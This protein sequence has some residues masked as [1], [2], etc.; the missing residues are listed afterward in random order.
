MTVN[1]WLPPALAAAG[2]LLGGAAYENTAMLCT[3]RYQVH[4]QGLPRIVQVSDLHRRVFGENQ[5]KLIEAVRRGE[6]E[7]IAVTG[8][9]V[10]RTETDFSGVSALLRSFCAIAPVYVALGNHEGDLPRDLLDAYCTAVTESGAELLINRSVPFGSIMLSGLALSP[11]YYRGGGTFGY[12]GKRKST[13]ETVQALLGRC[14]ER[15]VLLAHD[16]LCFPAYAEWGAA[17]TLSGH[18]HGGAVRLP[19]VGGLLSPERRFFPRYSKGLYAVGRH[20]MIV[21]AGLGKLRF[22]NPPE[23]CVIEGADQA[24]TA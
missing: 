3:S 16:P 14:Q 8:D 5:Q 15:T 10:S 2:V 7:L 22:H 1:K 20:E 13:A 24:V 17:L 11:D 9:L 12:S 23:I 6:P 21:S 18:V 19:L 4:M